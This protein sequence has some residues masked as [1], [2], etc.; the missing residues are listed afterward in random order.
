MDKPIGALRIVTINTGKGDGAYRQR[1]NVLAGQ[2]NE[3]DA[4]VIA[5]QESFSC[6]ELGLDTAAFLAEALGMER[7]WSPARQKPRLVE[8]ECVMS[9]SGMAVLSRK[10]LLSGTTLVLP[11]DPAD[12]DRVAQIARLSHEGRA[13]TLANVHLTHLR[14][15]DDL[16][17]AQLLEVTGACRDLGGA[18]AT[19]I[20]GDF[21]T[22][23]HGPVL[24]PMEAT[25]LDAWEAGGGPASR[26]TLGRLGVDG[27]CVDHV[28]ALRT[29][30]LSFSGS[31]LVLHEPGPGGLFASDH[32][33]VQTDLLLTPGGIP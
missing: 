21:N 11:Q 4:D 7:F 16:R 32:F 12:G 29:G 3:L 30:G 6:P 20:C 23:L 2:L 25:I 26:G 19:I 31:R 15:A 24:R 1:L 28:L 33:G 10:P 18:A 5:C 9:E 14:D 22:T 13:V 17:R 8:G 27:P